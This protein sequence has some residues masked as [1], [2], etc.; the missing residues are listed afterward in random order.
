MGYQHRMTAMEAAFLALERPGLPMHV[1]GVV[2]FEGRQPVTLP[3]LRH[4]VASRL[5]R[6][7]KFREVARFSP[8]EATRASWAPVGRIDLDA[9]LFHHRLPRPGRRAQ[10]NEL[11]GRIHERLLPR[12]RPLWEMHL[13]DGLDDGSQAVLIK[14]HHSI[15]DGIAGMEVARVLFDGAPGAKPAAWAPPTRF[16][17]GGA[18]WLLKGLQSLMGVAFTAAGGPI[19]LQGPFNGRVG[20]RR[21]FATA[22]LPMEAIRQV[23]R[24]HGGSVDDVVLATVA[25]GLRSYLEAVRY[26]G[27]PAALR[28]MVPVSTGPTAAASLGNHVTTV[29]V[30]L[31]MAAM[32]LPELVRVIATEKLQRRGA[33]EAA[34]MA[35]LIEAAG[36]LPNSLHETVVRAVAGTQY[37]NLVL[38]DVPGPGESMYLLGGRITACYPMIPLPPAIGLSIATVSMGGVM[39]VGIVAD[40]GLVPDL[41]RLARAIQQVMPHHLRTIH[42]RRPAPVRPHARR[43]A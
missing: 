9:H 2:V 18:A 24:R 13:I 23:K 4:L 40:P 32:E 26:P 19:A 5:R 33:H 6:L 35:L 29:F 17:G 39:S 42:P 14:T 36:W 25:M 20:A 37:A 27:G 28:A 34:G 12:E 22:M 21:A 7:P 8:L 43:A 41:S 1:A 30:D 10:L 16:A 11:C 3:D 31:P 15:T 38:S